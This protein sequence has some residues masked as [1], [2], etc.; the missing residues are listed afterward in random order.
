[1]KSFVKKFQWKGFFF[2]FEPLH[3]QVE[4]NCDVSTREGIHLH[5]RMQR[6]WDLI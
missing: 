2:F 3:K 4:E 6:E 5:M 1:M